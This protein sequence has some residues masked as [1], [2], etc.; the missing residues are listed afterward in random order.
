MAQAANAKEIEKQL[1]SCK[2]HTYGTH[3]AKT[4]LN[5]DIFAIDFG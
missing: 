1:I 5:T 2:N 4:S 3:L